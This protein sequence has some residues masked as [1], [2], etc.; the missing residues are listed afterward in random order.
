MSE[1]NDTECLE[2]ATDEM[3]ILLTRETS[4]RDAQR[5]DCPWIALHNELVSG[6]ELEGSGRLQHTLPRNRW[7][8]I[9]LC[10]V[11]RTLASLI[12]QL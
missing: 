9:I 11:T 10:I 4:S 6:V 3:C 12:F 2:A 5:K 7:R 8:F 1:Q